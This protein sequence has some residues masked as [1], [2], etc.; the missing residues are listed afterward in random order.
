MGPLDRP[1]PGRLGHAQSAANKVSTLNKLTGNLRS[2]QI[3]LGYKK[4]ESTVRYTVIDVHD[5]LILSEETE[6]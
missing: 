1:Q 6:I 4:L 5:T 3:L 2:G